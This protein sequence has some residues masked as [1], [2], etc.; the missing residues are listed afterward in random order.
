MKEETISGE[1]LRSPYLDV[2]EEKGLQLCGGEK[3][4]SLRNFA[5]LSILIHYKKKDESSSQSSNSAETITY[6]YESQDPRETVP[7]TFFILRHVCTSFL[8]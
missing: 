2:Q 6:Y 7:P 5:G 1:R 8:R 4:T 3:P